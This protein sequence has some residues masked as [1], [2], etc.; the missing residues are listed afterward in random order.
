MLTRGS[1]GVAMGLS[2]VA[3]VD[4]ADGECFE[5][6]PL[7]MRRRQELVEA[8]PSLRPVSARVAPFLEARLHTES[9]GLCAHRASAGAAAGAQD[10]HGRE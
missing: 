7:S 4:V 10:L 1:A 5:G 6:H 3:C 2:L 8:L 9:E